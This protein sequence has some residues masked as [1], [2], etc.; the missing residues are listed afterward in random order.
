MTLSQ[1]FLEWEE[2]FA[3]LMSELNSLR[4]KVSEMEKQNALLQARFNSETV[5]SGS[6]EALTELYNEGFHI[7]H[8][9]FA[10]A[11][12]EE[13]LFCLSFLLSEGIRT[14]KVK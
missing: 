4:K 14:D 11:R 13:C 10:Q 6:M 3:V 5:K 9:H 1:D 7:C 12:D 2:K 8:A